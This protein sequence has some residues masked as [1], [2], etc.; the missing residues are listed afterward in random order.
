MSH[1]GFG[2]LLTHAHDRIQ[3]R[4]RL[5]KDHG[6]ARPA[7]VAHV[8]FRELEQIA[9]RAAPVAEGNFPGGLRLRR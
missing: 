3:R 7:E 6:D 2:N 1:D 5:L 4:H 8:V 9:R